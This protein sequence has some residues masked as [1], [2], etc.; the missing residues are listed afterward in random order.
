MSTKRTVLIDDY[1]SSSP[2]SIG[3][4]QTLEVAHQ[5]MQKHR[6]R[7]LPVL[8]GGQLIGLLSLRDLHLVETLPDVDPGQVAVEDAMSGDPYAVAPGTPLA[9]VAAEMAE[10]KYGAAV[11]MEDQKIVG[12]FTTVDALRAL[13]DALGQ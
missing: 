3:K 5:M 6:I 8:H 9:A 10:H 4:E 12:V 1:M 7:H 11:V 13:V 2:H